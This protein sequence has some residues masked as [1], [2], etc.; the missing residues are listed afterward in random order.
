MN[1]MNTKQFEK[2]AQQMH[3]AFLTGKSI[4]GELYVCAILLTGF[5]SRRILDIQLRHAYQ[6]DIDFITL[7][8]RENSRRSAEAKLLRRG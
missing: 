4:G 1:W 2:F 5:P 7:K 6:D 8:I 3:N